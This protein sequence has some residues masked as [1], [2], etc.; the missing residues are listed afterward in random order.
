MASQRALALA[1]SIAAT[2]LAAGC[3]RRNAGDISQAV[4]G[5]GLSIALC[6]VVDLYLAPVHESEGAIIVNDQVWMI[7]PQARL[8]GTDLLEAGTPVCIDADLDIDGR[9]TDCTFA[10]PPP[11]PWTGYEN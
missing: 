8:Q 10:D 9:I 4:N 1:A 6:G 5:Q 3:G 7:A 2:L 11:D